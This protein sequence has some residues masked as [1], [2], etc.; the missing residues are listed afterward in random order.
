MYCAICDMGALPT[1]HVVPREGNLITTNDVIRSTDNWPMLN[2]LLL[3]GEIGLEFDTEG[4]GS[5]SPVYA[6]DPVLEP[7]PPEAETPVYATDPPAVAEV[8]PEVLA[9]VTTEPDPVATG[10]VDMPAEAVP[11][12][13]AKK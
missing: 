4:E 5:D 3:A 9:E 10:P 12:V 11:A 1:R 13:K 2:A 6:T 7:L 8:K